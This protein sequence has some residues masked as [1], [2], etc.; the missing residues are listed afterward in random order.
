M[1]W[2]NRGDTS[3]KPSIWVKS[4]LTTTY[5]LWVTGW[6]S[7]ASM[8]IGKMGPGLLLKRKQDTVEALTCSYNDTQC[9]WR[10]VFSYYSDCNYKMEIL[11]AQM[12]ILNL[13]QIPPWKSEDKL[14]TTAN[15]V[16]SFH[17]TKTQGCQMI[18]LP[19]YILRSSWENKFPHARRLLPR[20]VLGQWYFWSCSP[21]VFFFG[22]FHLSLLVF[23]EN[24]VTSNPA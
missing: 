8:I 2:K 9:Y 11:K 14:K 21:T 23:L 5:A 16:I 13:G 24:S 4:V 22:K 17:C 7:L 19:N 20:A 10:D 6:E 15:S 1:Y 18:S 3:G 12:F